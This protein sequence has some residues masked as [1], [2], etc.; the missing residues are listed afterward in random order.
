MRTLMSDTGDTSSRTAEQ[1]ARVLIDRQLE[2]SGWAVQDKARANLTLPGVAVREVVLAKGHGRADYVL[3]VDRRAVGVI[4]A[5]PEGTPLS[6]VEWQSARYATGLPPD[7]RL[8]ALTLDDRLPFVFEASGSE[9]HFTNGY[10]PAPRARRLFTF[11]RPETLARTVRDAEIDPSAA[12]WRARV[13]GMPSLITGGCG[14]RRSPPSRASSGRWP[15]SGTAGR[16]CSGP[17]Y[18]HW[19]PLNSLVGRMEAGKSF[20]GSA[21]PATG[22]EWGVI[23]VSAMTWG[24][25][26]PHENKAV[27]ADKVD[28]RFEIAPGDVLVSRANT[29]AYVGAPVLVRSTPPR[30][31]LSDKSLR[32][33]PRSDVNQEWLG[34]CCRH[35]APVGKSRPWRPARATRCATSRRRT[36]SPCGSPGSNP[37]SRA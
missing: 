9:V 16:R 34:G 2:A 12:T 14:R 7:V 4:E 20:G 3:Y 36:C 28:P 29:T 22:D 10:D 6:G 23:K 26:R 35:R 25:F 1:R 31:L 33:V 37:P 18:A 21:P 27:P 15:S 30:R 32:L 17:P 5:K 8:R 24:E 11:P 13:R 19:V